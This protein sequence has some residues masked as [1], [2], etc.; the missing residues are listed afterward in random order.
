MLTL[1]VAITVCAIFY[2]FLWHDQPA[3]DSETEEQRHPK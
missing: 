3:R 2:G 1:L